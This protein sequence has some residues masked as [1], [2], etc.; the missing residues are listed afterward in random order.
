M[1]PKTTAVEYQGR[2][3]R[4]E[5]LGQ[6]LPEEAWVR[7]LAGGV[8]DG[9]ATPQWVW[10]SLSESCAKGQCRWLLVRRCPAD[11]SDLAY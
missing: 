2:R 5:Q 7:V 10:L 9:V 8:G 4:A 1:V 3:E 6:R 11:P